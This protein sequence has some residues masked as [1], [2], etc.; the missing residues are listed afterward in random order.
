M[1]HRASESRSRDS[2][3]RFPIRRLGAIGLQAGWLAR[4]TTLPRRYIA[5][6][7]VSLS[8]SPRRD[9][10]PSLQRLGRP[11]VRSIRVTARTGIGNLELLAHR[12]RDEPEGVAAHV[13]ISDG[14]FDLRHVTGDTFTAGTACRVVRVICDRGGMR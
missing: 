7:T 14:L 5:R 10:G 3:A 6:T 4:R 13:D 11:L 9:P 2:R 8:R 12:R 1:R